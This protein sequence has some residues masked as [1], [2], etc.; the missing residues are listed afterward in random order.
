[1]STIEHMVKTE[2]EVIFEPCF[3]EPLE[4]YKSQ[5]EFCT[6]MIFSNVP[7]KDRCSLY[8]VNKM[9]H[10]KTMTIQWLPPQLKKLC[11]P[12]TYC[13]PIILPD[14]L[15]HFETGLIFNSPLVLPVSLTYFR[16]GDEF[17][18]P[19]EIP[20]GMV[21]LEFGRDF[22]QPLEIAQHLELETLYFGDEFNVGIGLP[23]NLKKIRLGHRFEQK[24]VFPEKLEHIELGCS[25]LNTYYLDQ[26]PNSTK[27]VMIKNSS[28]ISISLANLP[29][30][31][32]SLVMYGVNS[33]KDL[34]SLQYIKHF[35]LES[36]FK[37]TMI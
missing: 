29:N 22:N 7:V 34:S 12:D 15:E 31:V 25:C 4:M 35:T 16:T 21:Y 27:Y 24:I 36:K 6:S 23:K 19:L 5:L 33:V 10:A 14:T 20:I 26:L 18:Q 28:Y 11:L 32:D 13:K 8:H 17:N 1:M 30:S 37:R 2:F 3:C 9:N